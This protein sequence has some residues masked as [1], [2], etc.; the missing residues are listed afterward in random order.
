MQELL[1]S[2]YLVG[3]KAGCA[4]INPLRS[5]IHNRT[6][7]L[8]VGFPDVIGSSMRVAH[9]ISEVSRLITIKTLSHGSGTSF[10]T[11]ICLYRLATRDMITENEQVCKRKFKFFTEV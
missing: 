2:L 4:Y 6:N 7:A 9:I 1:C 5:T 11:Q 10:T 8:D 3:L